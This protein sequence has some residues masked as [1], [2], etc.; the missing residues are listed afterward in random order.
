MRNTVSTSGVC[1]C[2][3]EGGTG[4]CAHGENSA[5]STNAR[6]WLSLTE[7]YPVVDAALEFTP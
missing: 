2:G 4:L 5:T 7:P 3:A 6:P 1:W